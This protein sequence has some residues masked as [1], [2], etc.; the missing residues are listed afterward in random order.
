LIDDP[1]RISVIKNGLP[2]P[3]SF[4][5]RR[6]FNVTDSWKHE[7]FGR[8]I[9]KAMLYQDEGIPLAIV[10]EEHWIDSGNIRI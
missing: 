3:N 1:Y 5:R 9:E 4:H 7:T 10:S 6:G 2:Y 8:K